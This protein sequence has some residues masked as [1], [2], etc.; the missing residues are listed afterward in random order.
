MSKYSKIILSLLLVSLIL[1]AGIYSW[2]KREAIL[3]I[4]DAEDENINTW[5]GN[6]FT[7]EYPSTL[8]AHENWWSPPSQE[9]LWEQDVFESCLDFDLEGFVESLPPGDMIAPCTVPNI[10][11]KSETTDLTLEEYIGKNYNYLTT[12]PE[13]IHLGENDF[14]KGILEDLNGTTYYFA[15]NKGTVVIF[16]TLGI[17]E[18]SDPPADDLTE[19][20]STL[21]FE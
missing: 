18:V 17:H 5:G 9:G 10:G 6:G 11:V 12:S 4:E 19:M 21:K 14:T 16:Y 1:G 3:E 8:V 15:A 7:F 20:M 2:Q 13:E